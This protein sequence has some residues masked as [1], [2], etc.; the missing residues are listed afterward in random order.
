VYVGYI[1]AATSLFDLIFFAATTAIHY[2]SYTILTYPS[3]PSVLPIICTALLTP[4]LFPLVSLVT[5]SMH[6]YP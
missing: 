5:L 4:F 1:V 6:I 3:I 2:C